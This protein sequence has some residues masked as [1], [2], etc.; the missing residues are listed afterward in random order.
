MAGTAGKNKQ[1]PDSMVER[2]FIPDI[3]NCAQRIGQ[4]AGNQPDDAPGWQR[5]HQGLDGKNDDPPHEK[6]GEGGEDFKTMNEEHFEQH[7]RKGHNPNDGKQ[8]P[9]HDTA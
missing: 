2:Q 7:A 5:I 3:K 4:T 1:M 8:C 9:A 6:I